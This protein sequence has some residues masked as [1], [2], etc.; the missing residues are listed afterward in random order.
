M[1]RQN[2]MFYCKYSKIITFIDF[3][4]G[5]RPQRQQRHLVAQRC[6]PQLPDASE[7]TGKER[8]HLLGYG[9]IA[10]FV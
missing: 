4:G 5:H 7:S 3:W 1:D 10:F 8:N 9:K 2:G 6:N